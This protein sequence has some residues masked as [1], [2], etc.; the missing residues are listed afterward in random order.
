[1]LRLETAAGL[2]GY[3]E[4]TELAAAEVAA[5]RRILMGMPA[6][7][8]EPARS[9]LRAWSPLQ[10]AV[11]MAMLDVAGKATKAPVYQVL[12]GPTRNKARAMA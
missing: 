5:A 4:T 3:G 10:A 7:A 12:G 1:V 9:A 8:V 6:T 2:K 11:K